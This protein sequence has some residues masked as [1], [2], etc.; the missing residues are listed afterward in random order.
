M[1]VDI[2]KSTSETIKYCTIYADSQ[3]A[4]IATT[5]PV[6]QAGQSIVAE[7]LKYLESLQAQKPDLKVS[8]IWIPGHMDIPG[9]ERADEGAKKAAIST[10]SGA[11]SFNHNPLKSARNR[12][13]KKNKSKLEHA[14]KN[15]NHNPRFLQWIITKQNVEKGPKLYNRLTKRGQISQLARLRTGHCSLNH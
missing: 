7:A 14:W 10:Q 12:I 4:I 2:A 8:I 6:K 1:A 11:A 3:P 9:N 15:R 13:I 5:K